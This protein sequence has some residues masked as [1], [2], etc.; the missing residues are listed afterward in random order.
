MDWNRVNKWTLTLYALIYALHNA[1]AKNFDDRSQ[2]R[3]NIEDAAAWVMSDCSY[4]SVLLQ[5]PFGKTLLRFR[6]DPNTHFDLIVAQVIQMLVQDLVVIFDSMMDDLLRAYGETAGAFPQSKVEK[7]AAHLD[8]AYQWAKYGCLELI[9]ARNVLTHA[10]GRW[11]ART[12]AIIEQFVRPP[13][14][15]GE[16]LAIGF[17]MLFRYR[18]AM[19]TFL[20]EVKPP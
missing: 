10:E 17:P 20:N 8:Q 13:P 19:R 12:I 3:R 1:K 6:R 7:L 5:E 14:A 4:N 9:A 15:V 11:N 16:P 2:L 18:K